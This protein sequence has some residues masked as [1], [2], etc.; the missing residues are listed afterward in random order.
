MK[1]KSSLIKKQSVTHSS[2]HMGMCDHF[3][4]LGS[5]YAL[6]FRH[7]YTVVLSDGPCPG[8]CMPDRRII[9]RC[10]YEC[11]TATVKGSFSFYH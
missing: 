4:G 8:E 2:W 5:I 9:T 10:S 1:L 6:V 11:Q 7:D 3:C